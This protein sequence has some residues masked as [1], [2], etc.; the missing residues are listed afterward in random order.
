VNV[1]CAVETRWTT[2]PEPVFPESLCR[3][4]FNVFVASKTGEVEAGQ[5]HDGLA[6]ADE[7]GFWASWAGDDGNRG[8]VQALSLGKGLFER[9]WDPF[10][11]E[12]IDFLVIAR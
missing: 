12:F 7:L 1:D 9:L 2:T 11:D 10:V 8:K 4:L 5:V 3:L 6:G